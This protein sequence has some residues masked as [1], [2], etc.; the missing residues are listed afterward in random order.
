MCRCLPQGAT[1]F[2]PENI[3]ERREKRW[4]QKIGFA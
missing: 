2:C 4:E 3:T 1:F